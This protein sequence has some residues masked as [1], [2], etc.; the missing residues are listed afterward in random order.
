M[1]LKGHS[2][3]YSVVTQYRGRM[4]LF[5]NDTCVYV[6]MVRRNSAAQEFMT[7]EDAY[8]AIDNVCDWR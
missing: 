8:E 7:L 5:D 3:K 1:K 2:S 6:A 4:I